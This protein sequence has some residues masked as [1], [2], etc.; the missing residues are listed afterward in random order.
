M[1]AS[2]ILFQWATDHNFCPGAIEGDIIFSFSASLVYFLVTCRKCF[3]GFH[4]IS[5][6]VLLVL[7]LCVTLLSDTP[8]LSSC[9]FK[10]WDQH[11]PLI[12]QTVNCEST[13]VKRTTN[14]PLKTFPNNDTVHS[15]VW[16]PK[17]D[18]IQLFY[19]TTHYLKVMRACSYDHNSKIHTCR[20]KCA[21]HWEPQTGWGSRTA[22]RDGPTYYWFWSFMRFVD[23][24][25][26]VKSRQP[27]CNVPKS[28]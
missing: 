11:V 8:C 18:R 23:N 13:L 25:E 22:F 5:F 20:N 17:K 24:N 6:L 1:S 27:Q 10:V 4:C 15:W 16:V 19:G 14:Q 28:D 7:Q 21:W 9:L 26:N 12:R 3:H 2:L